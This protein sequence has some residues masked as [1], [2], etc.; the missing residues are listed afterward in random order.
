VLDALCIPDLASGLDA[1]HGTRPVLLVHHLTSWEIERADRAQLRVAEAR[2]IESCLGF[3]ATSRATATRLQSEHQRQCAIVPPGSDRL[4]RMPR[5]DPRSDMLRLLSVGSLIARKRIRGVLEALDRCVPDTFELRLVGD[6]SRDEAHVAELD[7][8]VA[9]SACLRDRVFRLGVV[10]DTRL[11][12]ELAHADFLVL[13]SS[14]EG[15]GMVLTEA[16]HAGLP[17][18]VSRRAALPEV[19]EGRGDVVV[20]E[21]ER[22][23][24]RLLDELVRDDGLR[25]RLRTAAAANAGSTPTWSSTGSA[26]RETLMNLVEVTPGASRSP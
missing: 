14:L 13:N 19:V 5:A 25:F 24:T 1:L 11:A 16:R 12:T 3:V 18:L 7:A 22:A 6:G 4:P 17:Q 21:D 23:L 26:F 20:F 2:T 9:A 10:D 8:I 15:Y